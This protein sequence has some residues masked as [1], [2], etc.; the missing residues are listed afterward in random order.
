MKNHNLWMVIACVL[1]LLFIFLLPVIGAGSGEILFIF[2]IFCFGA[3][4]L[5][6]RSHHKNGDDE[7]RP[8]KGDDH[9]SH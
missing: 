5:M 7:D 2:L 3:H 9:G 4:L 8:G 6:M 1:P